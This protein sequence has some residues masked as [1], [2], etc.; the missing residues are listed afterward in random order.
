MWWRSDWDSVQEHKDGLII[1]GAG[2]RPI[3]AYS[4]QD[5]SCEFASVRRQDLYRSN[6]YS[7]GVGCE[8][9]N[10]SPTP[11]AAETSVSATDVP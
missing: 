7:D 5:L 6:P 1:D 10:E 3:F 8:G 2:P 4:G 9:S 11:N